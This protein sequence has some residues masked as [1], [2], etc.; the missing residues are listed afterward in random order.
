MIILL[1]YEETHIFILELEKLGCRIMLGLILFMPLLVA[2]SII[3]ILSC[4]KSPR[5]ELIALVIDSKFKIES[6]IK[7]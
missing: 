3:V 4:T 1:L 6:H 5:K 2:N 7:Y